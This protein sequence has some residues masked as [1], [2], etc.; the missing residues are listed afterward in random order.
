MSGLCLKN[1]FEV[2]LSNKHI[3]TL[4]GEKFKAKII[5]DLKIIYKQR[6]KMNFIKRLYK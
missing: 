6:F 4:S 2:K 3:C 5:F 1:A